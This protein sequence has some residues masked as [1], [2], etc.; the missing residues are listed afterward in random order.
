MRDRGI[1][2]LASGILCMEHHTQENI[3]QDID[4][5]VG[6]KSDFVQFM[7]LTP[8]PVTALYEDHKRRGLLREDLPF[9]EW[10]GQ[11]E[12]SYR[13][14]HFPGD[15]ADRWLRY[16]FQKDHRLN[17]SSMFRV[18]DTTLRGY[19]RLRSR[20]DL[21]A[22]L[23]NRLKNFE[24]RVQEW[25]P[26]LSVIKRQA[27]NDLERERAVTLNRKLARLFPDT[28]AMRAMRAGARAFAA[29][30]KLRLRLVG[31]GLQPSTLYTKYPRGVR[32]GFLPI[33]VE[34]GKDQPLDEVEVDRRCQVG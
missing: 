8:L 12:L 23:T 9:E 17:S 16:A 28:L 27:V 32:T 24:R 3:E 5:M 30:W 34:G 33:P 1:L 11:H 7:L 14:P 2:V 26:M 4:F 13:H 19:E 22:C 25:G 31:D 15:S 10:H 6:L 21:D 20:K 18:V 29:A